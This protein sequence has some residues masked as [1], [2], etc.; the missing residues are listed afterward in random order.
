VSEPSQ[1]ISTESA[2]KNIQDARRYRSPCGHRSG[3]RYR[4]RGLGL[5]PAMLDVRG[6]AS[7]RSVRSPLSEPRHL[8]RE[9]LAVQHARMTRRMP[10]VHYCPTWKP[11]CIYRKVCQASGVCRIQSRA[12]TNRGGQGLR[13]AR[14]RPRRQFLGRPI[15][16]FINS[17]STRTPHQESPRR[18]WKATEYSFSGRNSHLRVRQYVEVRLTVSRGLKSK[19]T[20]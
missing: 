16:T 10:S 2:Q 9:L 15:H 1:D 14:S 5:W 19:P 8:G 11:A 20:R 4:R 6:V 12:R 17:I 18:S 7:S 3:S 13:S